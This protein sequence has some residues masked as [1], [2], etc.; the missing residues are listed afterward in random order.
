MSKNYKFVAPL[1]LYHKNKKEY[2]NI[3]RYRNWHYQVSNQLKIAFEEYMYP[4]IR[5][6][7]FSD[8]EKVTYELYA[9]QANLD[10][11]NVCAI[12]D[13]FFSDALVDY[14]AIL[15]DSI[16]HIKKVEYE[17]IE[18]DRKKP[19]VE[20]YVKGTLQNSTKLDH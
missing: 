2:F 18:V 17:F 3:N 9:H 6:Y 14:G 4:Q 8:I 20:I 19:R 15:D 16:K 12:V 13:K 1:Y 7:E 5:G 10:L 11:S